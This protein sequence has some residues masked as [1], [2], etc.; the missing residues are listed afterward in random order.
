MKLAIVL[1]AACSSPQIAARPPDFTP[2]PA[3]AITAGCVYETAVATTIV[4]APST[5]RCGTGNLDT[6]LIAIPLWQTARRLT[7]QRSWRV[8][9]ATLAF[10]AKTS[11]PPDIAGEVSYRRSPGVLSN[12][13]HGYITFDLVVRGR[14]VAGKVPLA[15]FV[16]GD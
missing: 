5:V 7:P 13:T 4:L 11:Q 1:V 2:R 8:S 15:S 3:P 16:A 6:D 12:L 14:H 9:R 10:D